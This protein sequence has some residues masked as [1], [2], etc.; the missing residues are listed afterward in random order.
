MKILGI[1]PGYGITGFGLIDAQRGQYRLLGCG[2]ITTPA[3]HQVRD[4]EPG[5]G[6]AEPRLAVEMLD[7]R[8]Q[9]GLIGQGA[10]RRVQMDEA[11][12]MG[13]GLAQASHRVIALSSLCGRGHSRATIRYRIISI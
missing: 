9:D 7:D 2:A 12:D 4:R 8:V 5:L 13:D 1:D 3:P 11:V 10:G 6:V